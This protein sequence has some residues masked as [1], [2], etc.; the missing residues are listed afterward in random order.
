[1]MATFRFRAWPTES[2][3]NAITQHFGERP[4]VYAKY[5]LP[6]H[7]GIDFAADLGDQIF[8]VAK[9]TVEHVF[10][11]ADKPNKPYGN[12][13]RIRHAN[14]YETIY[15]HLKQ[16]LVEEKQKVSAGQLIGL[17]G[18][19]GNSTGPHLH[20]TLKHAGE[21]FGTY[22]SN[23]I[24]PTPFLTHLLDPSWDDATFVR[25]LVP[26]G[27]VFAAEA[28]FTQQW[29]LR[30]S[31]NHAWQAG[32]QLVNINGST[33]GAAPS[34]PLPALPPGAEAPVTVSMI[35]PAAAGGYTSLWQPTDAAGNRFGDPVW[36][37]IEVPAQRALARGG[38]G[39]FVQPAG[40]AFVVQGRPFRFFG[41]NLRGLAHYGR[42]TTDPLMYSRPEHQLS[43]LQ[44]VYDLGARVV[45]LFL[46]DREVARAE[47]QARLRHLLD[48]VDAHFPDLYLLPVFTNLYPDVPFHHPGDQAD[49][50]FT[51]NL[52]SR[53]FFAGRYR[54]NYLPFVEEIVTAFRDDSNIF[55][56]E[57]GNELKLDRADLHNPNDPNPWLFIRFNQEVAA[58][59]KRIDPNHMVT[60]GMKSTHHAWLHSP[61]L[62]EELYQSPNL[63]FI[64]IHSYEGKWDRDGDLRVYE[65]AALAARCNK[66]FIVEEAG[67]DRELFP[68]RMAKHRD[69]LEQ[70]LSLGAQGYMP[71]GFIHAH[72]IGD[73]DHFVGIS[74][75]HGDFQPLC[76]LFRAYAVQFNAGSRGISRFATPMPQA[77]ALPRGVRSVTGFDFQGYN[78]H[79]MGNSNDEPVNDAVRYGVGVHPANV[80]T[81]TTYWQVVGIH[82]LTPEENRSRHNIYVDVLDEAG[83]RRKDVQVGWNWEGNNEPP[84]APKRLEKPDDEPG[85]DI[86]ISEGTFKLWIMGAPSDEA[87]GFHSRHDDEPAA[88]GEL[89]NT[90]GHHSFYVVFQQARK[91]VVQPVDNDHDVVV[92]PPIKP[93]DVGPAVGVKLG[94][95]K[96]RAADKIGIDANAPI[97]ESSGRIS[98][99]VND[100]S[101]IAGT[102]VGWVRL[103]FI[104]GPWQDPHDPQRPFGKSWRE[105][106]QSI[107]D[108]FVQQGLQ[109][110]GLISDQALREKPGGRLRSAPDGDLRRDGWVQ[111][112]VDTFVT[113]AHLFG[114][115]VTLFESFNE[116][117][118]WKHGEQPGWS[119]ANPNWIHP[120]W[121]ATILQAVYDAVRSDPGLRHIRLISGPLQGMDNNGNAGARY[122]RRTYAEGKVRYGWGQPG[123]PFPFDGVG[124]HL[125]IAEGERENVGQRLRTKYDDYMNELRAVIQD[126][127]GAHKPIF[128]SEMGWENPGDRDHLQQEA[129]HSAFD[130]ILADP[131]VALGIWFCTQDFPGKP[132]GL[133]RQGGLNQTQRKASYNTFQ[134]LCA[135]I[136]DLPGVEPVVAVTAGQ[137]IGVVT[138]GELN[139]RIG[140]GIEHTKI[141]SLTEN[142]QVQVIGQSGEWL[143]IRWQDGVA[144]VNRGFVVA[145]TAGRLTSGAGVAPDE[146]T[147]PPG[148]DPLTIAV[149]ETWNRYRV[150]IRR[151]AAQLAID[152]G[153]AVAVLV[154]ES[155]GAPFA[156]DG[157]LIIRFE[158][159]IFNNLWGKKNPA[160][161]AQHFAFDPNASWKAHQWRPDVNAAW[162]HC[163]TSQQMEW[164]V[165]NFARQ[166]DEHAAMLSIS[167]GAPQI[168]GF[169][170]RSI[171]YATVQ[172]MFTAF[173]QD[174]DHQIGSLFRFIEVNG[175]VGAIQQGDFVRFAAAYNGPGQ[176]ERFA[177]LMQDNLVVFRNLT[178][179]GLRSLGAMPSTSTA[180]RLSLAAD[181]DWLSAWHTQ[182]QSGLAT[183]KTL[184]A[185]MVQGIQVST[186]DDAV[187]T[188]KLGVILNAYWAQ[189]A[190]AQDAVA[191]QQAAAAAVAHFD[192]PA[193]QPKAATS[194]PSAGPVGVAL[195][196][197]A[198]G[199]GRGGRK[200]ALCIGIDNYAQQPLAGCVADARLWAA[201]LVARGFEAPRLL[202]NQ[203]ATRNAILSAIQHLLADSRPGD[204]LVIQYAGHG[205]QLDD[206]S[207]DE[208]G[209]DTPEK[210]E[211]LVPFDFLTGAYVLDDDLGALFTGIPAGVNVTCF[212]DCCH[213]GSLT[214]VILSPDIRPRFIVADG[215]M[216][217]AH[218]RYRESLGASRSVGKRELES[219]RE[220]VF[221]ACQSL[222]VAWES[223]GHGEFTLHATNLLKTEASALSHDAFIEQVITA[224]GAKPRQNPL[225][226]CATAARSRLLLETIGA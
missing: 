186:L 165:F 96:L 19:T 83:V 52:L 120:G 180:P 225:L 13:V 91:G 105:T 195:P 3:V 115:K 103:N 155:N 48:L 68:D 65:D 226:E 12:N 22:H 149:A 35:A 173:Q 32:Y 181:T 39:F 219:M 194:A 85:C 160:R 102:G 130:A 199:A 63:D 151:E 60:T 190:L 15:A 70:W 75:D 14:G 81:G 80:A 29:F 69:H 172:E 62:Q 64:T 9:G 161:F 203:E 141:G 188:A 79:F 61:A 25:D 116:P 128:I 164:L 134:A 99:Q 132:Y 208:S 82:H 182:L 97:D 110:Y 135:S 216:I 138:A 21:T 209:G 8:A 193:G 104:I 74:A 133:Y 207:G 177:K 58:A 118:D 72:E 210:D 201:T 38:H 40:R 4:E 218:R 11:D 158:N 20:L 170:H 37:Q 7:E 167:M 221:S 163:H 10:L 106:Y 222:E 114:D 66:P 198:F 212:M 51:N 121:F 107:I 1:M 87:F 144:F 2:K 95:G 89:L 204:I 5:G 17:A 166:L 113:I 148:A 26:D 112:Y 46:A 224:F 76:D 84:P 191:I 176:A 184:F 178:V 159:H 119:D 168:M 88:N 92:T 129:M 185:A 27:T 223:A 41:Y 136:V 179:A 147:L 55:A 67:F 42:R 23:I 86:P 215:A 197:A 169:N 93:I 220:V 217:E 16:V 28:R 54:E 36:V 122:L 56:W 49:W 108:G 57:I 174:V 150:L 192:L 125:Y 202:L 47:L 196:A 71:W 123:V 100:P 214:R 175:L 31:G 137:W 139:V 18:S 73:S 45:R 140:P 117:D 50:L 44:R 90:R 77:L 111:S 206:V 171:G 59:I 145:A 30:N 34:L 183:S 101:L 157:K 131:S 94:S 126:E 146:L 156:A 127:E 205:I 109:I 33:L 78:R 152:P 162:Q 189:L 98:D 124:Y 43:Q 211:A 24:D 53:D 200:R 142:S 154:T 143:Q 213:S 153:V 6:G 187:R